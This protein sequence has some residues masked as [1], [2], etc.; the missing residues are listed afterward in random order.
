MPNA[1]AVAAAAEVAVAA[2]AV[3][4]VVDEVSNKVAE[5]TAPTQVDGHGKMS[6]LQQARLTT[7]LWRARPTTD[8]PTTMHGL[9]TCQKNAA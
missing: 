7:R 2:G 9:F 3:A 1:V 8:A 6:P 5:E 4:V